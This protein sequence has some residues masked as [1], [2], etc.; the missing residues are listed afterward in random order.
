MRNIV[1]E[2]EAATWSFFLASLPPFGRL[3]EM[4]RMEPR[5]VP[6]HS[7]GQMEKSVNL[8]IKKCPKMKSESNSPPFLAKESTKARH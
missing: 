3:I 8:F 2:G 1:P 4:T 7:V 6:T 5:L